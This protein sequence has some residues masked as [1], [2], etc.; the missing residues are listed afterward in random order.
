MANYINH[1]NHIVRHPPYYH[2]RYERDLPEGE[3]GRFQVKRW[4]LLALPFLGLYRPIATALSLSLGACRT[5][6]HLSSVFA[7]GR[8]R[9]WKRGAREMAQTSLAVCAVGG[10]L[11]NSTLGLAVTNGTDA[12]F[13]LCRTGQHFYRGEYVQAGEEA[14]QV[15]SSAFYLGTMLTGSLQIILI[16]T[17]LQA[18]ISLYQ[19]RKEYA[20]GRYPEAIAKMAMGT[21]RLY[22][23]KNYA[24]FIQ[25]QKI[26]LSLLEAR[27]RKG[28]EVSC[29]WGSPIADLKEKIQE[30]RVVMTDAE[31]KEYDFGA[32]FHG[33]GKGLVKGENLAFRTKV[34]AGKSVAELD[35]KVNHLFRTKMAAAIQNLEGMSGQ[36]VR[37]ALALTGSHAQNIK[38]EKTK[39]P[40]GSLHIG[41]AYKIT[42][43][44][45]G[46]I[47][48]GASPE[49][50]NLHDRVLVQAD[51]EKTLYDFHEMLSFLDLDDV[52]HLSTQ[53][54]RDRLKIGHLFHYFSPREALSFERSEAFFTLPVDQLR[55]EIIKQSPQMKEVF[56]THLANMR[57][58]EILPGRVRYEIPGIAERAHALGARA[59]TASVTGAYEDKTLYSRVASMLKMGMLSS[60][61]RF[62]N[63]VRAE[64]MSRSADFSTGGADSVFTQMLTEKNCREQMRLDD[65]FYYNKVQLLIS[66]DA[67]ETGSYQYHEDSFGT[68][69]I[70]HSRA[71]YLT[72]PNLQEF[73]VEQ[74]GAPHV[75]SGNEVMLK[76]RVAPSYIKGLIVP[77]VQTREDL[78]AHL[79]L[80]EI[81]QKGP[82]GG[83]SI[84]NTPVERFIRVG[85]RVTADLIA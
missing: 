74:Q 43:D 41:S 46:T 62:S 8:E 12:L 23:A 67:L 65:L 29:L 84:L 40:V 44:G 48:V 45:L 85:T 26:L 22:Q 51:K 81:V 18:G 60:E 59:L 14:V 34:V 27:V 66:L 31:K 3:E 79:R 21:I 54:D 83:E 57:E 19:A 71:L 37:E 61:T 73:I 58:R 64:G 38:I 36:E 11:F 50:P 24:E 75:Y 80:H 17:L 63:G 55:E 72:R 10:T 28:K 70:E 4:A 2:R 7:A 77:D 5:V 15:A 9:E 32:H 53:E 47:Q 56:A 52:L 39:F 33:F 68:R 35:F 49:Y 6:T 78:L 76:E 42:L 69:K 13:S 25:R 82:G 20:A 1:F 16:S 30:R